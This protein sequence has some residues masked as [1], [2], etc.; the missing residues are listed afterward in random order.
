MKINRFRLIVFSVK[1]K[2][3]VEL[4][5]LMFYVMTVSINYIVE[6]MI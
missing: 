4:R 6:I 1:R 3:S 2:V 5:H